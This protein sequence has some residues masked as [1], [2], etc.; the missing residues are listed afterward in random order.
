MTF[1]NSRG[2]RS[3]TSKSYGLPQNAGNHVSEHPFCKH[4][5]KKVVKFFRNCR[6]VTNFFTDALVEGSNVLAVSKRKCKL[7]Q[8]LEKDVYIL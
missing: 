7:R 1:L 6:N 5:W 8:V 2:H 4:F 3:R